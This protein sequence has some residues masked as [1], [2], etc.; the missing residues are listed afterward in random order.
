MLSTVDLLDGVK[1]QMGLTRSFSKL[2]FN[3]L[4]MGFQCSEKHGLQLFVNYTNAICAFH[5]PI[6][7]SP[8]ISL[9]TFISGVLIP[10]G[11]A[12]IISEIHLRRT[13]RKIRAKKKKFST[14][15][16][17]RVLDDKKKAL[18][19][20]KQHKR[21]AERIAKREEKAKG[22]VIILAR[23][24]SEG[25]ESRTPL[26]DRATFPRDLDVT[27]P[28]QCMVKDGALF[29]PRNT[30]LYTQP[31]FYDMRDD[32][33]HDITLF[34]HYRFRDLEYKIAFLDGNEIQLPNPGA[35]LDVPP[36]ENRYDEV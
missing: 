25:K 27:I 5:F 4:N 35:Q 18:K 23:Y 24:E 1:F 36:E 22:L 31:G 10:A 13:R 7:I 12:W 20:Q 3:S 19:W 33:S 2:H 17:L 11:I 8:E 15:K 16:G 6:L 28:V 14:D 9:P 30:H 26:E 21:E 32:E 34:V 29:V